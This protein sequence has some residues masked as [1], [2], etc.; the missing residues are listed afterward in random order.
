MEQITFSGIYAGK[1]KQPVMYI[2]ERAVFELKEDG[3]YITEIAPGICY[4]KD[5]L[6]YMDFEPKIPQN[7]IKIMDE[8]I[9]KDE[10]MK[11]K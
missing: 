2:T 7:G 1:I 8:R 5:I 9:F 6:P 11:L 4:E 3:V 10:L